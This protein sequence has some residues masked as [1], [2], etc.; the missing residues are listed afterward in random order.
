MRREGEHPRRLADAGRASAVST[1]HQRRRLGCP[2]VAE[3]RL[4]RSAADAC[5]SPNRSAMWSVLFHLLVASRSAGQA[6]S[7]AGRGA[8]RAQSGG[9]SARAEPLA[10]GRATTS[11][12][13]FTMRP[14]LRAAAAAALESY[15][16]RISAR[17][18]FSGTPTAAIGQLRSYAARMIANRRFNSYSEE[19]VLA[20]EV[21]YRLRPR[22]RRRERRVDQ[23]VRIH[24]FSEPHRLAV[25]H[26]SPSAA[27]RRKGA[28]L[29][30]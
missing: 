20:P 13:P 12:L 16:L 6:R 18:G 15:A 10:L 7:S 24:L 30:G 23:P 8:A 9:A 27:I 11:A 26:P 3:L 22:F 1:R 5:P 17:A 19:A 2:L 25:V 4:A 29:P 21:R 14:R 28:R